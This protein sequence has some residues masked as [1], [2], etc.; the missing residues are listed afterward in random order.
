MPTL[1]PTATGPYY[2]L[3]YSFGGLVAQE[4]AVQLRALNQEIAA[5]ILLDAHIATPEAA[6]DDYAG[7]DIGNFDHESREAEFIRELPAHLLANLEAV[8]R[9]NRTLHARHTPSSYEG[10]ILFVSTTDGRPLKP[11]RLRCLLWRVRRRRAPAAP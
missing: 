1:T 10:R 2:L 4:V 8:K 7:A 3:S 11:G 9:N 5:L 6:L